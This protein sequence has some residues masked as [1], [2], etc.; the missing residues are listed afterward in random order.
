MPWGLG[1]AAGEH[2]AALSED[3]GDVLPFPG[4]G[5]TRGVFLRGQ[6]VEL[7]LTP[8]AVGEL[9]GLSGSAAVG[10][11]VASNRAKVRMGNV[12]SLGQECRSLWDWAVSRLGREVAETVCA[13]YARA[14]FAAEPAELMAYTGFWLHGRGAPEGWVVSAL[15]P[16]ERNARRRAAILDAGG[17]IVDGVTVEEIEV[18]DGR[19]TAVLTD[20]GREHADRVVVDARPADVAAWLP[21]E[22]VDPP[23]QHDLTHLHHAHAAQVTLPARCAVLPWALHVVDPAR[24]FHRLTRPGLLP[25]GAHLVDHVTA[26]LTLDPADPL[27]SGSDDALVQAVRAGLEGIATPLEGQ[28]IVQRFPW[29]VPQLDLAGHPCLKRRIEAWDRLGILA[30]GSRATMRSEELALEAAFLADVEEA[31]PRKDRVLNQHDGHRR[32]YERP[33]SLPRAARLRPLFSD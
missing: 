33:V 6:V 13:P 15:A 1:A 24:P 26:H 5:A 3:W 12:V 18:E 16:S 23:W 30:V 8:A 19:V 27:W 14:R 20:Q 4:E 17:D 9:F 32:L 29:A 10:A 28:A 22:V 2:V 21:D 25:G 7:P 31:E 11:Q